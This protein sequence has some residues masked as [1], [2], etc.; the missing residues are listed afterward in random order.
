MGKGFCWRLFFGAADRFRGRLLAA[1]VSN[2]HED[3]SS[4]TVSQERML[5][6]LCLKTTRESE[7][8]SLKQLADE[9]GLS[10]SAVSVMVEALVQK[11]VLERRNS[12]SDR[13]QVLI[14]LS[15]VAWKCLD[16]YEEK[17][18]RFFEEFSPEE[19]AVLEKMAA[20]LVAASEK[21]AQEKSAQKGEKK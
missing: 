20:R 13:R 21:F 16:L 5:R 4:L 1:C 8:I 12:E 18:N 14:R 6:E 17:F 19:H 9:L 2:F 3:F 7:G 15:D 11:R 10:S